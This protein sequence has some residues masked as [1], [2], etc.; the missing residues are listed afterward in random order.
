VARL[1]PGLDN[2]AFDGADRLFVSSFVDGYV[3]RIEPDGSATRLLPGGLI[4]PSGITVTDVGGRPTLLVTD[5]HGI[6]GYDP[7]SGE[8]TLLQRNVFGVGELGTVL[9]VAPDG[10]NLV[11][12]SFMDNSVR[13]WDPVAEHTLKRWDDLALPV[14]AVRYG[15]GIAVALHGSNSVEL[16]GDGDPTVIATAIAAPTKLVVD[17][18]DLLVSDRLGGQILRIA[19]RGKAIA[20][21]VVASGLAAPEGFLATPRG[22]VVVEGDSGRVLS[23]DADGARELI[24]EVAPGLPAPSSNQPPAMILSDVAQLGSDLFVSSETD[25]S[26]Y[27]FSGYVD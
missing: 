6:R 15:T 21:E 13:I 8:P 24:G 23:I 18:E 27:R 4:H 1:E 2:L 22:L 26:I 20:P 25:R 10:K 17:G 16:L 12:S 11:L 14:S 19:R 7:A 9:A 5:L 3:E